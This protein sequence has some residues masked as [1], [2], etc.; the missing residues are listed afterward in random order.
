MVHPSEEALSRYAFD[1]NDSAIADHIAQ[2]SECAKTVEWIT[3]IDDGLRDHDV[4]AV[5]ESLGA[6]GTRLPDALRG[7]A[8]QVEIEDAEAD[9]VLSPL[10][11]KPAGVAWRDFTNVAEHH[12]AGMVRRL[13]KAANETCERRPLDALA[14]ADAASSLAAA[15]DTKRYASSVVISLRAT[16]AKERAN[17]LRFLGRYDEALAALDEAETLFE[18]V[19]SSP[20][21]KASI[22]YV[23]AGILVERQEYASALPLTRESGRAFRRAGD[24]DRYM[25]ARH[26]EAHIKFYQAQVAAAQTIYEEVLAYGVRRNDRLWIARALATLARCRLELGDLD[27]A[28]RHSEAARTGFDQ[29]GLA[30]EVARTEWCIGRVHSAEQKFETALGVLREVR[31]R[32]TA[33]GLVTDSALVTLDMMDNLFALGR[34]SEIA[35]EAA[36]I[37]RIFTNAG[38]L[39]SALRAFAYLREAGESRR[40]TSRQI[41][42]V[43]RFLYR[44]EREPLLAFAPPPGD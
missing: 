36:E 34:P 17:A 35:A 27:A 15:L 4:W 11:E 9:A 3:S 13:L 41:D 12:T 1:G 23:R 10:L 29:L 19:P 6:A 22:M 18:K 44:T 8:R 5:S 38:M 39:T 32:F 37:I 20:I 42:H 16:A 14:I 43:R 33:L 28:R 31:K 30:A 21:G 7:L 40:I 24:V 26:L 2:C 25:R